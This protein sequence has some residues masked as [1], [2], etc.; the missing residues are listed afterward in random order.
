M[1]F[2]T[3][4]Y[5]ID[6]A[7]AGSIS[8]AAQKNYITQQSM[9][10]QLKN[11][12]DYYGKTLFKRSSPLKLTKEGRLVY[13]AALKIIETQN[14]LLDD[15]NPDDTSHTITI[16]NVYSEAP[17]FL[18]DLL[19][20]FSESTGGKC[21]LKVVQNCLTDLD[22]SCDLIFSTEYNSNGYKK[23]KLLDD[24]LVC[25]VSKKLIKKIY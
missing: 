4:Q 8:A 9:S 22:V 12:E 23:I 15:L 21:S 5:F 1:N 18:A 2:R 19:S 14:S 24:R 20:K 25:V 10:K 16:G 3:L 6:I 13:D 11:I 17:P 7:D